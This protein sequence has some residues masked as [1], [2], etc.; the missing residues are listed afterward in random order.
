MARDLELNVSS[1]TNDGG[2]KAAAREVDKLSRAADNLGDQFRQAE[3]AASSLDR[4]LAE[5]TAAAAL[6]AREFNKTG[7]AGIKKQLDA[8]RVAAAELK[9]LRS[10]I[11]G[12]TEKDAKRA[13]LAAKKATNEFE[14]LAKKAAADSATIFSKIAENGLVEGLKDPKLVA[15]GVS[16]GALLAIPIGAAIG[17]A[18]LAGAA[19]GGAA[20]A[21]LAASKADKSGRVAAAG[22]GLASDLNKQFLAG[23]ADAIEPLLAGIKQLRDATADIHLDRIIRDSAKYIEPLAAGAA[24][25]ATYLSQGVDDLVK[26]AGPEIKVLAEELPAIGRAIKL[27]FDAIGAGSE[28]GA[29]ALRDV[30]KVVEGFIEG[31]G[32]LIGTL[33]NAYGATRKFGDGFESVIDKAR[34][35]NIAVSVAL[36]PEALLLNTFDSGKKKAEQYA[37]QLDKLARDTKDLADASSQ[38]AEGIK[39]VDTAFTSLGQSAGAEGDLV[40]KLIGRMLAVDD[41]T[42]NFDESLAKLDDTVKT[43]G[44]SLDVFNE[45]TGKFNDKALANEKALLAAVKANQQVYEQ[46]LLS[47]QSA[48][49]AAAAYEHNSQIL[50]DQAVAAGYNAGEVDK[51]IGKYADVPLEVKTVL[52]T[53]GLTSALTHLGQILVDLNTLDKKTFETKYFIDTYYRTYGGAYGGNE[54]AQHQLP[55][56]HRAAGGPVMKGQPYIVGEHRPEVFVPNVSGMI[57]PKVP[58]TIGRAAPSVAS[59]WGGGGTQTIRFE[60]VSTAAAGSASAGYA[61]ITHEAVRTGAVQLRA[62]NGTDSYPVKVV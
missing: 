38:A 30:L 23:G 24:R 15:I 7:D 46:N 36:A 43:N 8:Q 56:G 17:G 11:I 62:V 19:V 55:P 16:I 18:V 25:M 60:L 44:S 39:F 13:E 9:R 51:L 41:A 53:E 2:L 1:H 12:D 58:D 48:D 47:G 26:S 3:R 42:L 59:M 49:Q 29:R 5:T 61:L 35:S 52:A 34:E 21:G 28:G 40:D 45:K 20:L 4:K 32:R 50:R 31:T 37:V 22:Q 54:A 10:D 33:E 57:L 6:L 27:A 14:K